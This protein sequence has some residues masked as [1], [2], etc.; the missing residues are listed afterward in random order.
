MMTTITLSLSESSIQNAIDDL[1][2]WK[3]NNLK[4]F[5]KAVA[6]NAARELL[7]AIKDDIHIGDRKYQASWDKHDPGRLKKSARI[8]GDGEDDAHFTI[9]VDAA[10]RKGNVYAETERSRAPYPTHD[11]T[12]RALDSDNVKAVIDSSADEARSIL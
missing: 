4:L 2:E 8:V 5:T 6:E 10:D 12:Y 7:G 1:E 9:V 3:E 11:F